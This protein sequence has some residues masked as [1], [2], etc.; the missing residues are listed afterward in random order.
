MLLCMAK[1]DVFTSFQVS[2]RKR[3]SASNLIFTEEQVHILPGYPKQ[4]SQ[5]PLLAVIAFYLQS[6]PGSSSAIIKK[7][8]L[9]T[10]V[11]SSVADISSAI[12]ANISNVQK[13]FEDT[14]AAPQTTPTT[15]PKS[16]PTE[17]GESKTMYIIAGV[18]GG[19]V[20]LIIIAMIVVWLCKWKKR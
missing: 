11:E 1:M 7:D 8:I 13:L 5:V 18:V 10:I 17:K 4:T 3:R 20:F 14:T 16:L 2:R 15:A 6:P 9:V 12:N 19:V